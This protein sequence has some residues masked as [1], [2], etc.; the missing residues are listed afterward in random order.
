MI[1]SSPCTSAT[2]LTS[3]ITDELGISIGGLMTVNRQVHTDQSVFPPVYLWEYHN[4]IVGPRVS[5]RYAA[6][7][8]IVASGDGY[9]M[10]CG[11]SFHDSSIPGDFQYL[12]SVDAGRLNTDPTAPR[13][14]NLVFTVK[15]ADATK[16]VVL[17]SDGNFQLLN[18]P[19]VAP[20]AGSKK[21][22]YDPAAGNVVKF[23]P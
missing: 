13:T 6:G 4:F 17:D 1:G 19:S 3:L 18:L 16:W 20:A 9:N 23:V 2:Y 15:N 22:W 11:I 8:I 21:C 7:N 10:G 12:A 14:S 5:S